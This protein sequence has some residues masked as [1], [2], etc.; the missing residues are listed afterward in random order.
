MTH[1]EALDGKF[2]PYLDSDE[3]QRKQFTP[4]EL[5]M[6]KHAQDYRYIGLYTSLYAYIQ[7]YTVIYDSYDRWKEGELKKTIEMLR[8]ILG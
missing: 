3:E 5:I 8:Y 7:V 6:Y 2:L 1:A 4:T